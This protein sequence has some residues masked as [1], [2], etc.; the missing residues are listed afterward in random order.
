MENLEKREKKIQKTIE[1]KMTET[2]NI[3]V[4]ILEKKTMPKKDIPKDL[5]MHWLNNQ[6]VCVKNS[7]V[8]LIC[9]LDM[10]VTKGIIEYFYTQVNN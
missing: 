9:E 4:E 8:E 3:I 10:E 1:E 2:Y 6:V 5:L 7:Y